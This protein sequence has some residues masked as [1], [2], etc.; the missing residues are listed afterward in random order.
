[1]KHIITIFLISII[2][3]T[4]W[5]LHAATLQPDLMKQMSRQETIN[6]KNTIYSK[7]AERAR[8]KKE[9]ADKLAQI[10]YQ[11][12]L[13]KN[14]APLG[15]TT[16]NNTLVSNI[17]PSGNTTLVIPHPPKIQPIPSI[18]YNT[19]IPT[20]QNVDMNRVRS[21]WVNWYNWVRQGEWLGKYSYDTRLDSSAYDWN[22]EL[23]KWYG[24]NHHRRNPGDSYYDFNVIDKWFMDR[25]INPKIINRSKHT[26]NVWYGYY[27]CSSGDCTDKL[28]NSIESTFNFFMSEKG[29]SY[30]AHYR[31][32]V[33]PY[34]T[35]IGLSVI[36]VPSEQRYYLTVHYI[37]E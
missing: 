16:A 2:C 27:T 37:T 17:Q 13:K 25:G 8:I 36:V 15:T 32:I 33:N 24:Q 14:N 34:F 18:W 26:E 20:P 1:M 9:K 19:N 7:N 30:D 21:A 23:A 22:V 4:A 11:R 28:I 6:K 35:K 12:I 31:S 10:N 29:K 5:S 3:S